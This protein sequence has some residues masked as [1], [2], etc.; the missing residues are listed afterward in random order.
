MRTRP[1]FFPLGIGMLLIAV[2]A[3]AHHAFSAEFDAKQP[4]E[5]RG[6]V[7]KIEMVNPHGWIHIDVRGPD[8]KVV[9]WAIETGAPS[10]LARRGVKKAFLPIG[11][12]VIV[13]GYRAKDMTFTASGDSVKLPDGRS[14]SVAG[15]SGE[16]FPGAPPR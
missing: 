10:A 5:L 15:S 7:T 13:T 8:G 9:N 16:G 14:F 3:I 1:S 6:V 4:V 12:E 2:P 11:Q